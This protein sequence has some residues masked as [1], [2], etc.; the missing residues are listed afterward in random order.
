MMIAT[1]GLSLLT[2]S[3]AASGP[4]DYVRDVKPILARHCNTCHG[5]SK[6]RAGLR[7]DT[8]AAAIKAGSVVPGHADE[9]TLIDAVLGTNGIERMPLN[10]PTTF[11]R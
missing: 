6:P 4:V 2:L 5:A 7:L 11:V 3:L 10:R 9:S 1:A 8:A